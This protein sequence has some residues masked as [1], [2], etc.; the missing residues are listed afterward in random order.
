MLRM[1]AFTQSFYRH[2]EHKPGSHGD[3]VLD[4]G[5]ARDAKDTS[6]QS[7]IPLG[8]TVQSV[9]FQVYIKPGV[10]DTEKERSGFGYN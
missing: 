2:E 8:P 9:F 5:E 6:E 4:H 3:E 1:L 7:R 10:D